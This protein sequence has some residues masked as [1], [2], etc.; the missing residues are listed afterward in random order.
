MSCCLLHAVLHSTASTQ[1]ELAPNLTSRYVAYKVVCRSPMD[2]SLVSVVRRRYSDFVALRA[3]LDTSLDLPPKTYFA[4]LGASFVARRRRALAAWLAAAVAR[5]CA[6]RHA[7]LRA[8]LGLGPL[9]ASVLPDRTRLAPTAPGFNAATDR[10]ANDHFSSLASAPSCAGGSSAG[11][12]LAENDPAAVDDA[13]ADAAEAA[14]AAATGEWPSPSPASSRAPLP[15]PPPYSATERRSLQRSYS[16][17]ARASYGGGGSGYGGSPGYG[18]SMRSRSEA[19]R[20]SLS[21]PGRRSLHGQP[22]GPPSEPAGD[23]WERASQ[24]NSSY[25]PEAARHGEDSSRGR[26]VDF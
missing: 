4:S 11:L 26:G 13:E 14:L 9:L 3:T 19:H 22:Q 2:P 21:S 7:P 24:Q 18:G 1:V 15:A 20:A 6:L 8:F 25:N 5:F 10:R 17:A 12:S 23:F 16:T